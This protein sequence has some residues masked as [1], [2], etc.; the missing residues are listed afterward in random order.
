MRIANLLRVIVFAIAAGYLIFTQDHSYVTG[1]NALEYAGTALCLTG[2]ALMMIQTQSKVAP[3]VLLVPTITSGV[4]AYLVFML[5]ELA[6]PHTNPPNDF[7]FRL[8][9]ALFIIGFAGNEFGLVFSS[10]GNEKLELRISAY[11]GFGFALM[12][13]VTPFNDVNAVGFLS[14]YLIVSAVQRAIW[15]AT[16]EGIR[17]DA[18]E[19]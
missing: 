18:E 2:G 9:T 17:K 8:L 3:S 4:V 19:Q 11:I 15:I 7:A 13:L 12:F 14:A 6:S 5:G 1:A 10:T 16:P